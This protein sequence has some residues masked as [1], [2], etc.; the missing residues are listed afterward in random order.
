MTNNAN[1][2][3]L[4]S[5]ET[6]QLRIGLVKAAGLSISAVSYDK[7]EPIYILVIYAVRALEL[8]RRPRNHTK[9]YIA[10]AITK[11][12]EQRKLVYDIVPE[13]LDKC[14]FE[15]CIKYGL[16]WTRDFFISI[17]DHE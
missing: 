7:I 2:W 4:E 14:S 8:K 5:R 12:I 10:E 3:I 6:R 1:G 11:A 17:E 15:N 9:K 13:K 16:D